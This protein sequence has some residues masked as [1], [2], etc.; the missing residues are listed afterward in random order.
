MPSKLRFQVAKQEFDDFYTLCISTEKYFEQFYECNSIYNLTPEEIVQIVFE[1]NKIKDLKELKRVL[2]IKQT[3]IRLR[4][5]VVSG[6]CSCFEEWKYGV[7]Q[8]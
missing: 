2:K 3:V 6:S 4:R 7:K 5:K 8:Q 1:L